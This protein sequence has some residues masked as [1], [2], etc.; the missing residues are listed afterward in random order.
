M[1]LSFTPLLA[2]VL[3]EITQVWDHESL[4]KEHELIINFLRTHISHLSSPSVPTAILRSVIMD[5]DTT[6]DIIHH[7]TG[8]TV[9]KRNC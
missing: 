6:E 7:L 5:M 3:W 8:I 1:Y 2:T 4:L 9:G